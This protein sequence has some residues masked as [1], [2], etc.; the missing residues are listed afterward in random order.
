MVRGVQ[1]QTLELAVDGGVTVS[2]LA[3]SDHAELPYRSNLRLL[4]CAPGLPLLV[5]GRVIFGRPRALVL[6]AVAP[7][8]AGGRCRAGPAGWSG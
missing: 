6:L 7:R 5:V 1:A 3:A 2:G 8:P 4:G